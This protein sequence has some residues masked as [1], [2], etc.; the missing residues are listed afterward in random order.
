MR[1][2][3][4][5]PAVRC[6]AALALLVAGAH[7]EAGASGDGAK[8][9]VSFRD[10]T[11]DGKASIIGNFD[12]PIGRIIR[13]EGRRAKPSKLSNPATLEVSKVDGRS[14][15]A[16]SNPPYSPYIQIHNID[17]L[18]EDRQIVVEGYEFARWV[19]DPE[20]NWLIEVDFCVTKVIAPAG[21][22]LKVRTYGPIDCH[23]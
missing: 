19:G 23:T 7:S 11:R 1:S 10:L 20:V 13:L 18:P 12:L 3:P 15:P 2:K 16:V 8:Q 9:T 4:I 17:G 14:F 5:R 6:V 21:L 22:V